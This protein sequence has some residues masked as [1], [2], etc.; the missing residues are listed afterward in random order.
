MLSCLREPFITH[1]RKG[2]GVGKFEKIDQK[3]QK[4]GLFRTP[5]TPL[6]QNLQKYLMDPL[7]LPRVMF[8]IHKSHKLIL[9]VFL[10]GYLGL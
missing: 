3:M 10:G 1:K 7:D 5:S 2:V 8:F 6:T 9:E 4:N